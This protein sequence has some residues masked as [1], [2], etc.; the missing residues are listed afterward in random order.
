MSLSERE[1]ERE[2]EGEGET[3]GLLEL[4]SMRVFSPGDGGWGVNSFYYP[5]T[6]NTQNP[7]N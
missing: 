7:K 5:L 3:L 2:R 4:L 1:R 6:R